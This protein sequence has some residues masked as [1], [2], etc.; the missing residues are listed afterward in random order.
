MLSTRSHSVSFC[1]RNLFK[2]IIMKFIVI[3]LMLFFERLG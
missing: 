2:T 1:D 3:F